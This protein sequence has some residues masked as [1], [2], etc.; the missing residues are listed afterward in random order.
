MRTNSACFLS[1]AESKHIGTN[2]PRKNGKALQDMSTCN[3]FL[4]RATTAQKEQ[5]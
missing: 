2:K 4:N 3:Y 5:D 1:Y